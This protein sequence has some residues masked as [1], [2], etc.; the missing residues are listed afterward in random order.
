MRGG[1]RCVR[2]GNGVQS[3]MMTG[4]TTMQVLCVHNWA[5]QDKVSDN[6]NGKPPIATLQTTSSV[7]ISIRLYWR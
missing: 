7:E 1:W 3:A 4:T 2:V 5:T 6:F